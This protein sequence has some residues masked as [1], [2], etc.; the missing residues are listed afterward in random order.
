MV[1]Y[2]KPK[3]KKSKKVLRLH[4]CLGRVLIGLNCLGFGITSF[5][6]GLNILG[7]GDY[8]LNRESILEVLDFLTLA[9]IL[10]LRTPPLIASLS[11]AAS[12]LGFWSLVLLALVETLVSRE[13]AWMVES[14][15]G[16]RRG[17]AARR[18]SI[19][20]TSQMSSG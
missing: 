2:H 7:L 14:C 10:G 5:G 19:A 1:N 9:F 8:I 4:L 12:V 3:K 20:R 18:G 16:G 17:R 6:L 13:G 11:L 15:S